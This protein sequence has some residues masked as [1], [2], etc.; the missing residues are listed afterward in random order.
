MQGPEFQHILRILNTN[1]EGKRNV[2]IGLTKIPGIGRRF[3]DLI[4]IFGTRKNFVVMV[5]FLCYFSMLA[6]VPDFGS[7]KNQMDEMVKMVMADVTKQPWP[8]HVNVSACLAQR[9]PASFPLVSG[10]GF[11]CLADA[12]VDETNGFTFSRGLD[13]FNTIEKSRVPVLFVKTDGI[14]GK[15]MLFDWFARISRPFVLITH[16]SDSEAPAR[17][18]DMEY[19]KHP[20]LVHWFATNTGKKSHP[21]RSTIPIGFENLHW[22]TA[23][24]EM[25]LEARRQALTTVQKDRLLN[26]N[27]TPRNKDR[28]EALRLY[29]NVSWATIQT[30][31]YDS[32][33]QGNPNM[34]T[35]QVH[36]RYLLDLARYK[37]ALSPRG[38]GIDCHRT[39]ELLLMGVIPIVKRSSIDSLYA[40]L[41]AVLIVDHWEDL[42]AER[43]ERHWDKYHQSISG[44]DLPRPL[45]MRYWM[46]KAWNQSGTNVAL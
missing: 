6:Y 28:R 4:R 45:T 11:R 43:L 31:G 36:Q 44:P 20:K 7:E 8:K 14:Q 22:G 21:K 19:L 29:Q 12:F 5:F 42:T 41:P 1:V 9:R 26:L 15:K 35:P 33:R 27:F 32:Y 23:V 30:L 13:H 3:S 24:P 10:D 37:F 17:K 46:D 39:W 38:N 34:T 2:V 25:Y 16:N 18:K 40:D